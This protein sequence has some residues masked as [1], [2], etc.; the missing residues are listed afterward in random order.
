MPAY[1]LDTNAF[2]A[3]M[4]EEP[5]ALARVRSLGPGDR[6]T[7][8]TIVR[9]E[10]IYGLDRMPRGRR[11]REFE[12]KAA[13]LFARIPCQELSEEVADAYARIKLD[14]E[15]AGGPLD[16]NDL[17]IAATALSLDAVVVTADTDFQRVRGLRIEDWV[18]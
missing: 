15:R 12:A 17:W 16:D 7:I 6:L 5:T 13:G 9:G 14:A 10:V 8:C 4:D 1:L 2:S 11:R 3:L 18:A